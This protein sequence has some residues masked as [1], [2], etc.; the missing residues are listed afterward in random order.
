[1]RIEFTECNGSG[2]DVL[3][4]LSRYKTVDTYL[5]AIVDVLENRLP[6]DAVSFLPL[7]CAV[8]DLTSEE[9]EW[10]VSGGIV[11]SDAEKII[12]RLK[13]H[14]INTRKFLS[15]DIVIKGSIFERELFVSWE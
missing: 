4:D 14:W 5:Q 1:M 9:Y 3:A 15:D 6:H 10:I 8:R 12:R 13:K 2:T 7:D 11:D